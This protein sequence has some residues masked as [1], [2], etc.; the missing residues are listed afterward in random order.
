MH[1]A[2]LPDEDLLAQCEV[3]RSRAGGPGGQ[4]RNKVETAVVITHKETGVSGQASERRSQIDNKR[5]A[6]RR[7]RLNLA[8]K[9]RTSPP[10][11]TGIDW[12]D[13]DEPDPNRARQE[14]VSHRGPQDSSDN[15]A[16]F[17]SPL[18]RSR[19]Q[20]TKI[21]CS[22]NH[23]DYPA[24]LA[25]ALD[26]IASEKWEPKPAATRLGVSTSQLIKLVKDYPVAFELWNAERKAAK[27]HELH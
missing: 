18:W 24:L 14:A 13:K 23:R 6:L 1:P 12:M 4:H 11:P 20:G 7:L 17:P 2:T 5:V 3:G 8:T 26:V 9:H 19:H 15:A 16:T 21:V 22:P 10:A 27:K 25:E